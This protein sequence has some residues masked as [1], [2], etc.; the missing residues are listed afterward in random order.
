MGK[1]ILLVDDE[2][3]I[4]SAL[5]V[6]FEGAGY[7]ALVVH[8]GEEAL[9][10]LARRTPDLIVLD[11]MM[12]GLDGMVV[13]RRV[14]E[15]EEYIPIV[16]LTAKDAAWEKVA[17]LEVGADVYMTKPFDTGELMAQVK[18]L[19]RMADKM[20]L[21]TDRETGERPLTC[22]DLLLFPQQRRAE[23]DGAEIVLTP[24]EF[25]LL[26]FLMRHPGQVFGRQTLLQRVWGDELSVA[27]RTV[28]TH[29]G[30]LRAK[31]EADPAAPQLLQTVRGFGYR[32]APPEV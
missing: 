3:T 24:K 11:V 13:C 2:K 7:E 28:D 20:R 31:I 25:E 32:L 29:V 22:G 19:L 21:H 10:Q 26:Y 14:R 12:P 4:T 16:M 18:A 30:R 17:G 8:S 5:S 6:L 23:R 15:E 27:S 1:Y 9:Q